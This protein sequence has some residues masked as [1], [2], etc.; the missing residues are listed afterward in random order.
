[1]TFAGPITMGVL[2]ELAADFVK[3]RLSRLKKTKKQIESEKFSSLSSY[4]DRMSAAIMSALTIFVDEN[5]EYNLTAFASFWKDAKTK[6]L[7]G[8]LLFES[9]PNQK[10]IYSE[11]LIGD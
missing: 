8:K 7:L 5:P 3:S 11:T 2:E 10:H 4:A 1:M 9:E 6:E